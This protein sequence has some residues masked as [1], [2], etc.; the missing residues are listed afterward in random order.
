MAQL[1]KAK[2]L[3]RKLGGVEQA[4]EMVDALAKILDWLPY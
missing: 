2:T 4:K 1:V 3:V